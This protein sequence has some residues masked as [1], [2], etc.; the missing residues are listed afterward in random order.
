MASQ[1]LVKVRKVVFS[2]LTILGIF[3]GLML[4]IALVS[5]NTDSLNDVN[6]DLQES[7]ME[8]DRLIRK[9]IQFFISTDHPDAYKT[10]MEWKEACDTRERWNEIPACSDGSIEEYLKTLD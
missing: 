5:S 8:L 4:A 9:D 6:N 3:V 1:V 10:M 7:N 2:I